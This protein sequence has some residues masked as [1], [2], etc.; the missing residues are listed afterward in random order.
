MII[1]INAAFPIEWGREYYTVDKQEKTLRAPCVCCDNTGKVEIKGITYDCP[2]CKGNWREKEVVGTQ[3]V[4][5]VAK[6]KLESVTAEA[7]GRIKLE[8]K[9]TNSKE[10]YTSPLIIREREFQD[11]TAIK[12]TAAAMKVY[13]DRKAVMEEVKRLNAEEKA[14][15]A[16]KGEGGA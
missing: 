14:R 1:E 15:A 12:A 11:M 10:R 13:N 16:R 9:R 7:G 5:S 6:W 4:Y 2:R 3:T 8:F